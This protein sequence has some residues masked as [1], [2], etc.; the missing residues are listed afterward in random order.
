MREV[1]SPQMFLRKVTYPKENLKLHLK[2]KKSPLLIIIIMEER[3]T[4]L[5]EIFKSHKNSQ[6]STRG[7]EE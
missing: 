6:F 4:L 5:R 7:K 2:N 1:H 3:K